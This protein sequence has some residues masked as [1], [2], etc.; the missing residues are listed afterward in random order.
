[1]VTLDTRV[2]TREWPPGADLPTP[3]QVAATFKCDNLNASYG[4]E[5]SGIAGPGTTRFDV[6]EVTL[7]LAGEALTAV[8]SRMLRQEDHR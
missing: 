4:R 1:M 6:R 5:P 8:W 3:V 2:S 7:V